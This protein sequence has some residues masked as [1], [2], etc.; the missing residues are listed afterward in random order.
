MDI[1]C[2]SIDR[3]DIPWVHADLTEAAKYIPEQDLA[4]YH[5][6]KSKHGSSCAHEIKVAASPEGLAEVEWK[7]VQEGKWNEVNDFHLMR[8]RVPDFFLGAGSKTV[9]FGVNP[10]KY[11]GGI[12]DIEAYVLEKVKQFKFL[13]LFK[14]EPNFAHDD[15][16]EEETDESNAER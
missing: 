1:F 11:D 13:P 15:E 2:D 16:T 12:E 4:M 6:F 8:P 9:V 10:A 14:T 3:F 7:P 5:H